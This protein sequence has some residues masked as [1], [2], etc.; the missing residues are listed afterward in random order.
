MAEFRSIH[1]RIWKDDWFTN[2]E[3][4]EKLLFVYLFSNSQASVC[5]IYELPIRYIAFESGLDISRVKAILDKFELDKKV[6][7]RNGLVWVVN[8][9]KYNESNSPKVA[10]RIKKDLDGIPDCE[11][12]NMYYRYHMDTVSGNRNEHN[13]NRDGYDTG[14]IDLP[15]EQP[16]AAAFSDDA[17]LTAIYQRVTGQIAI[18][19]E[20]RDDSLGALRAI[21]SAKHEDTAAV[22]YLQPFWS[23]WKGRQYSQS[24]TAWLTNWAVSGQIPERKNGSPATNVNG[25]P[26]ASQPSKMD[27]VD[28]AAA[29]IKARKEAENGNS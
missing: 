1:T 20:G 13:I 7:Y 28:Q 6:Y 14:N 26:P 29:R 10:I 2:L 22:L 24:N 11:L 8:L 27:L 9:R 19:A 17:Q 25:K 23:E 12:K 15:D 18:P 3:T 21:V 4:D 5:G 16:P